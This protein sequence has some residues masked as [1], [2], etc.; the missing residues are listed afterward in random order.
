[1]YI[2]KENR[3]GPP[4]FKFMT[5]IVLITISAIVVTCYYLLFTVSYSSVGDIVITDHETERILNEKFLQSTVE[6]IGTSL[7]TEQF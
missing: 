3:K 7:L 6:I 4:F 1:M 5:P 2:N